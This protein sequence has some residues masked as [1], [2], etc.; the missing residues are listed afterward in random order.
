MNEITEVIVTRPHFI[1]GHGRRR[2][3]AQVRVTKKKGRRP[4]LLSLAGREATAHAH[5]R[6]PGL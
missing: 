1:Y 4:K 5:A 3:C 6:L 2:A